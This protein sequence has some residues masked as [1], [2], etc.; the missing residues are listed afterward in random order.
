[1]RSDPWQ[2]LRFVVAGAEFDNFSFELANEA[3]L[4]AFLAR[5]LSCEEAEIWSYMREAKADPGL[6]TD[7]WRRLRWRLDYTR[8]PPLGRRLTWYVLARAL[9]PKL[10]VETGVQDGLGSLALLRAL[11]HNARE[12]FPGRL[13]SFDTLPTAGWLVAPS[14]RASWR[15]VTGSSVER[16]PDVLAGEASVELF[17]Q[18]SGGDFELASGELRLVLAHASASAVYVSQAQRPALAAFADQQGLRYHAFYHRS[19]KHVIPGSEM[20]FAFDAGAVTAQGRRSSRSR[21]DP[22]D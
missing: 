14:E 2:M 13:I 22:R 20:G 1:M 5:I 3:E 6:T 12:G 17:F 19:F 8:R 10:V 11:D 7:L 16:M 4:A 21:S 18:D 9:T 15:L